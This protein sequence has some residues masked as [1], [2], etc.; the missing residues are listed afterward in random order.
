MSGDVVRLPTA[1]PKKVRQ[2]WSRT[3]AA[4]RKALL[5]FPDNYKPHWQRVREKRAAENAALM[6]ES[7]G[8]TALLLAVTIY[9]IL[10]DRQRARAKGQL[11]G[12]LC[13]DPNGQARN[14]I[15]W[16]EAYDSAFRGDR[17]Q[18]RAIAEAMRDGE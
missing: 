4:D 16:L 2:C 11:L 9:N 10:D 12:H 6:L 18:A 5:R 13:R 1:A 8:D 14:A 3:K 15:A 17:S 7:N